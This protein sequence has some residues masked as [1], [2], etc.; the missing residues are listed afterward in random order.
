[1]PPGHNRRGRGGRRRG[2]GGRYLIPAARGGRSPMQRRGPGGRYLIPAARASASTCPFHG[3]SSRA[4]GLWYFGRGRYLI[5]VDVASF[6]SRLPSP[7]PS[8]APPTVC[9]LSSRGGNAISGLIRPLWMSNAIFDIRTFV[10]DNN[11][12]FEKS[13]LNFGCLDYAR[14]GPTHPDSTLGKHFRRFVKNKAI[15]G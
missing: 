11:A 3:A 5:A 9:G 1:M 4:A 8:P 10:C 13:K 14:K 6:H 7:P 15:L 2:P 12:L